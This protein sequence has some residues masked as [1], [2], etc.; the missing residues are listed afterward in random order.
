[1]NQN[2]NNNNKR[3]YA[4]EDGVQA[5][6][7]PKPDLAGQG[8]N[9]SSRECCECNIIKCRGDFSKKQWKKGNNA[10]TCN[11][12]NSR[13][14]CGTPKG[15][16]PKPTFCCQSCKV[17][18]TIQGYANDQRQAFRMS[19][20]NVQNIGTDNKDC[21]ICIECIIKMPRVCKRCKETKP[22]AEFSKCQQILPRELTAYNHQSLTIKKYKSMDMALSE[23]IKPESLVGTYDVIY[24]H[25]SCDE[26]TENRTTKGTCKFWLTTNEEKA[27]NRFRKEDDEDNEDFEDDVVSGLVQFEKELQLKDD[28]IFQKDYTVGSAN[29]TDFTTSLVDEEGRDQVE[30]SMD[31][32]PIMSDLSQVVTRVACPWMKHEMKDN[33]TEEGDIAKFE[34]L[35]EAETLMEQHEENGHSKNHNIRPVFFLEPGDLVLQSSWGSD[36]FCESV[37]TISILR[38]RKAN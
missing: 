27:S 14:F 22:V 13:A 11:D 19:G 34:T 8:G 36:G 21:P 18:K 2:N 17:A 16:A 4:I 12:C 26:F 35:K 38:A 9:T 10:I 30:C 6:K 33:D 29:G 25:G 1:M 5:Q 24:H 32:E 7:K 31:D 20:K 23:S 3:G 37:H 28:Y 15:K